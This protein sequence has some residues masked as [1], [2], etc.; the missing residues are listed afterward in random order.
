MEIVV[1]EERP[2][3][4]REHAVRAGMTVGRGGSDFEL[5][6]PEVSR[7]HAVFRAVDGGLGIE[8]AGSRNG[9][10]VNEQRVSGIVAL[11]PGDRVRFGNTVWRLPEARAGD[12]DRMPT[13]LRRAVPSEAVYGEAAQFDAGRQ[14]SP[15]LGGS[16][17]RR[18]EATVVSYLVVLATAVAVTL[19]FAGR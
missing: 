5:P 17:A 6:D 15:T 18:L 12:P 3:S 7:S 9:T 19:Y 13:A 16:A 4:G 2:M 8:D 1:V 10:Y 11:G 14:P